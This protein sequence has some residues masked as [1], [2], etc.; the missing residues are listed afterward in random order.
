MRKED[1]RFI[2]VHCSATRSNSTYSVWQL[3]Q[4]HRARGFRCAGYHFYIRQDGSI[5]SLRPL[6]KIGAHTRAYNHCSIGVCYE[7]GLDHRAEPAD[8]RNELQK[9]ALRV[10]LKTL[11]SMYPKAVIAGHRDFSPDQNGDGRVS[12]NEWMKACPCFDAMQEYKQL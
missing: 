3:E 5:E 11:K 7:G 4:D 6:D 1:V 12:P 2:I 8:T 10:L 9:R